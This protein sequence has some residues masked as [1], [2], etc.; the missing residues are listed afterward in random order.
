MLPKSTPT[1]LRG[2]AA[3]GFCA[4]TGGPCPHAARVPEKKK[5]EICHAALPRAARKNIDIPA[6]P[7][8]IP[9][10]DA[11]SRGS[12]AFPM[13]SAAELAFR[14]RQE[15]ANLRLLAAPPV[16][17]G[18]APARLGLPDPQPAANALRRSEFGDFIVRTADEILRHR[19]PL[20]GTAIETGP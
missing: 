12:G 17:R 19:F 14:A 18:E 10:C 3:A 1:M 20:F 7:V 2:C 5:T 16:F 6:K 15:A 9:Q 13:R 4:F 11:A 8:T